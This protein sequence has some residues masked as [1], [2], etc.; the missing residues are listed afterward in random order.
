[1]K[2]FVVVC[3]GA[4]WKRKL[5]SLYQEN[6]QINESVGVQACLGADHVALHVLCGIGRVYS[7]LGLCEVGARL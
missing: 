6:H 1:M 7:N 2:V 5:T 4:F 3:L